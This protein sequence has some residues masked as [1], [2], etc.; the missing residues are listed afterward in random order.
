MMEN[1]NV[2]RC[3]KINLNAPA[4]EMPTSGEIR[5]E[6]LTPDRREPLLFSV[7]ALQCARFTV[8]LN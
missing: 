5:F 1:K 4:G 2:G 3:P 8:K 6:R 7:R